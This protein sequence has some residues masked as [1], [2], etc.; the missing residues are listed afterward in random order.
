MSKIRKGGSADLG[1]LQGVAVHTEKGGATLHAR[2]HI[3][4]KFGCVFRPS[5]NPNLLFSSPFLLQLH[6]VD[7]N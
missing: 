2:L 1:T 6:Q 5:D 3:G 7:P 4:D